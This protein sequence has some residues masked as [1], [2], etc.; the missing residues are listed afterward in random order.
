[1]TKEANTTAINS[2]NTNHSE[3]DIFRPSFT[4]ILVNPFLVHLGLAKKEPDG[5]SFDNS[6]VILE[7]ASGTGK[8][9]QN[10]VDNGWEDNLIVVEP[11]EGMMKTFNEKFPQ[12]KK[13]ILSSSYQIPLDDDSVD[14]VI[15]AQ[16]FHWFADLESLKEIYRILKPGGKLGLI[17]NFDYISPCHDS[18]I[19]NTEYYNAGSQYFSELDLES[20]L[21][22]R[23][24]FELFFGKQPWNKAVT[25]YIYGFDGNVPQ[26][27][28][29][30]WREVLK[31][32]PYFGTNELNLFTFYD[33]FVNKNDVW[34]YWETRSYITSLDEQEKSKVKEHLTTLIS[35]NIN[36]SSYA[37]KEKGLLIKPMATHAVVVQSTKI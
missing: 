35:E 24:V 33:Q 12:I 28:H 37:D 16:G 21:T 34:K 20:A 7:I 32:N 8:F 25:E 22:N 15:I 26:Y 9:T 1:M 19:D 11:S 5:Y 27:R 2:F 17:W 4:P 6:K 36:S 10:L 18:P 23:Q 31:K 14:A 29:G 13:Q 3:Y 30:K